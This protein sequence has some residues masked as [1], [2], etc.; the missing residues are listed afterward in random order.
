LLEGRPDTCGV[1]DAATGRPGIAGSA[2]GVVAA[3][4]GVAAGACS[5]D[6]EDSVDAGADSVLVADSA[7]AASADGTAA[8]GANW[9]RPG[10]ELMAS[11]ALVNPVDASGTW[12]VVGLL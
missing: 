5:V 12:S 7:G 6:S 3:C 11:V 1:A 2:P 8:G 9:N 10:N 4:S